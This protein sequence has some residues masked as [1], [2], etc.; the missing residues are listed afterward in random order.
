MFH[1]DKELDRAVRINCM[2][3]PG[4]LRTSASIETS[5]ATRIPNQKTSSGKK[6]DMTT[7][8]VLVI[9]DSATIRKMV[10]SHLSQ[11][12]YRVVLAANGELGVSMA[13]EIRPDLILLDHQ[14]PGTT[15]LEV[16]RKIIQLPECRFIPFVVSSTLRKQAYVEYMDVPNVVDS[17]PKPF[18]P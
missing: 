4:L 18:K 14:L 16:C 3:Q 15:G 7:Q 10:D 2:R 8:T 17:L 9:D 12:G 1:V 5:I 6:P 11:E 13:Q